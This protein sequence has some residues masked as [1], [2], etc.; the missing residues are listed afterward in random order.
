M[1]TELLR[2]QELIVAY[3]EATIEAFKDKVE[4][5]KLYNLLQNIENSVKRP[6]DSDSLDD[7]RFIEATGGIIMLA[8][9]GRVT[10]DVSNMPYSFAANAWGVGGAG[11]TS[12]GT[13]YNVYGDS[14]WERFFK[15]VR[16]YHAQGIAKAGGIYQIT[17]FDRNNDP[18]GQFNSVAIGVGVFQVGGKGKWKKNK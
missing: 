1:T 11:F 13:M 8:I 15:E 12:L 7:S 18:I 4:D 9:Y 14:N 17:W 10:C 16:S 6:V 3:K 2:E 5:V